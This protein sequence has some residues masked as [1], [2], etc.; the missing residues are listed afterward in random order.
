MLESFPVARLMNDILIGHPPNDAL[1]KVERG[2]AGPRPAA[3]PRSQSVSN[4]L[5][6]PAGVQ[7]LL[8][9]HVAA[10]APNDVRNDGQH[11]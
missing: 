6:I 4:A 9:H 5:W 10:T 1:L 11:S 3:L 8:S 7:A 2:L